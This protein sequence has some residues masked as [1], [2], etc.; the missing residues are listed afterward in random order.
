MCHRMTEDIWKLMQL[1]EL[2]TDDPDW[3]V[4][5]STFSINQS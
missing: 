1:L 4:A 2:V 3:R 5:E